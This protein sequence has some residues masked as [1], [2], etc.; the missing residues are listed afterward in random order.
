M[1][2]QR[3][4]EK[5]NKIGYYEAAKYIQPVRLLRPPR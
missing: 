4:D 2:E 1:G 3:G 5:R